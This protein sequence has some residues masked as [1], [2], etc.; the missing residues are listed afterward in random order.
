MRKASKILTLILIVVFVL[1]VF[2]GCDLIGRDVAKYRSTD[3]MQIGNETITV[4]KLLDTFNSYYNQYY[5]YISAGYLNAESLLEMA[6][7]SL[8][9]Q[10]SQIDD[11]V[12]NHEPVTPD[13][14]DKAHNAE[15]LTEDEFE[16]TIKYVRYLAYNAFDQYL[17]D[18]VASKYDLDAVATEDT[19]RNFS[20]PDKLLD[21]T[22]YAKHLYL[23]NFVSDDADE[24]FEKYYPADTSFDTIDIDGYVYDANSEFVQ[25]RVDEYNERRSEDEENELT[26]DEYISIQQDTLKQYGDTV[27]NNYGISLEVFLSNQLDD[28]ISG[29]IVAKWNYEQYSDLEEADDLQEVLANN[30]ET[31]KKAFQTDLNI[32]DN[33]NSFITGLSSSSYLYNVPEDHANEYVFVKNV[34]IPFTSAQTN[35]L[36][37]RSNQLGTKDDVRYTS[38]RDYEATLIEADYF[39]SDKYDSALEDLFADFLTENTDEDSDDKYEKLT[40][41]FTIDNDKL[42]VNPNGIL[43]Q[44]FNADGS[45]NAM[46]NMSEDD[47]II[48]LMKRFNTDVGQHTAQ[49][50]YVVYVGDDEDYS[51]NWVS[52]FVDATKEAMA[53]GGAG[54]YALGVSDYGVHI[55]YVVGFVDDFTFEFK[56]G[57]RMD[58]STASY[59]LFKDYFENQV[60]LRTQDASNELLKK[61]IDDNKISMQPVFKKF[62]KDN[63]FTFDFDE[64]VEE[65]KEEL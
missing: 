47:T 34:L 18:N 6:M 19:S 28:M 27:N 37:N 25:K 7:S 50:D 45:V 24:Y 30:Y 4:G 40:G 59:R 15:Y 52:E 3:V 56:F 14:K 9:R 39:Y 1:S 51:H 22:S 62:L 58:T 8:I 10:Y 46:P 32:N 41:I 13:L 63:N 12:Q 20:E 16:Y 11:Y 42:V 48:E 17:D 2:A 23:Q 65:M 21:D 57:D 35:R 60:S 26:V 43:G 64:F 5:Y 49:Y 61:Y 44:F 53:A 31:L 33:F 29:C 55:V 38:V 36:T 54:H